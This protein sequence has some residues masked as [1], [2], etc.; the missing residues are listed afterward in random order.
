MHDNPSSQLLSS[1]DPS[2]LAD[3]YQKYDGLG[4][5]E[6]IREKQVTPL[7]LLTR[8]RQRVELLNPKLNALCHLFFD[9]A[10]AQIDQG[11]G[12]GLFRGVP[13]VLKDLGVYL[14]GTITSAGS[15]IWKDTVASFDSTLVSRYKK[16]GLVIFGKSNSP[17]IGLTVTTESVLFGLTRNPWN[18]GLTAGGSSGGSAAIVASRIVPMAHGSDG[19]GSIRIPASCCG[20]FGFKPT[21]GRVPLGPSQFE[22]WNGCSHHHALT[23]SVRDSAALLDASV[24]QEAGSPFFSPLPERPF[25]DEVAKDPGSLRIALITEST[26]GAPLDPEC[27]EAVS[28]AAKLCGTLGHKIEQAAL[29]IHAELLRGALLT[30]LQVSLA[31]TLDDA[32]SALGR[33]IN[34]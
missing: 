8:V 11:L 14:T 26:S 2:V 21:R 28:R 10:E 23:V 17:E 6:L 3:E 32:A 29:P 19:G 15:R 1:A 30:V 16:A 18:L 24:G 27:Q 22:G 12:N 20:V 31:R 33:S 4:L 7:E 9:R 34:Q 5:A 13:F 25:L